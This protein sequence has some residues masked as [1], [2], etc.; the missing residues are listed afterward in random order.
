MDNITHALVGLLCAEAVVRVTER[1]RVLDPGCRTA[2]YAFAIIGNN[3]PDLDFTYSSISGKVFGYLL[4]HRGYSHTLPAAVGFALSMLALLWGLTKWRA[5]RFAANDWWLLAAVA[6]LSP[7]LHLLMDFANNYGV[8][9]FWPLYS[10]WFYGDSFFILEPSFWLVLIAPLS[11]SYRSS[12]LRGGLWSMLSIAVGALWYRPFVPRGQAVV[13]SLLTLLLLV[14]ARKVSPY[15]RL[16]L[17]G[18]SFLFVATSFV[19]ASRS[20]KSIVVAQ[21]ALVHPNARSMDIVATPMPANPFCWSVLL[22]QEDGATYVVR[23]G[24]AAT[25]PRWLSLGDCPYDEHARPSAPLRALA[26]EVNAQ[27]A[28]QSEYR[29]PLPELGALLQG[30]CEGRAFARFA[31]VPYATQPAAD[32]SVV[33][34][35]LRYDRKPGLDFSDLS[36][37]PQQ[38]ACPQYV[39]SWLPP[40]SDIWSDSKQRTPAP[41]RQ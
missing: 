5:K 6:L 40:R 32:G 31:R 33:L 35:D 20:V 1:R 4:Q 41:G 11:W 24:R 16:L 26:G 21:A 39:P 37:G 38:A 15:A 30:R 18:S 17:A 25:W 8:H 10:G 13:L 22:V 29:V 2:I 3:L 36:L 23:L 34:G 28:W 27:L 19:W 12:W 14:V 7:L 9:P